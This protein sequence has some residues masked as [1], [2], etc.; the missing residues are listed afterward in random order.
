MG[1]D[2]PYITV[3]SV[4][5]LSL[6]DSKPL[7]IFKF[8]RVINFDADADQLSSVCSI[9]DLSSVVSNHIFYCLDV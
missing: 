5:S 2:A 7:E 6:Y 8:P 4:F 1:L 9:S 3:L